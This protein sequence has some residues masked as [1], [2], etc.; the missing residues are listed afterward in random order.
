[1][2]VPGRLAAAGRIDFL[3]AHP[4]QVAF[5]TIDIG[6][7]DLVNRC[8]ERSGL[9]AKACATDL[10]PK[11]GDRVTQIVDALSS[12]AGPDVPIVGMTY[13]N[14]FLGLWGTVRGGRAL[15]HADQRAWR[16]STRGSPPLTEAPARRSRTWPRPSGSTTSRTPSS[17]RAAAGSPSMSRSPV[18]GHSSARSATSSIPT[19][20]GPATAGSPKRSSGNS[21]RC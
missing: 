13:Y 8:L 16:C 21:G 4:G 9:I 6:S 14:P 17:C 3:T 15:A 10:A 19:R 12:A 2:P 5:V 18:D 20:T 7:N 11:L 1:M